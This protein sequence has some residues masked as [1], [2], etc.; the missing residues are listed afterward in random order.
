[1]LRLFLFL[2]MSQLCL[3][4]E[5]V[6]IVTGTGYPP[7][8]TS[9]LKGGGKA[10]KLIRD[11]FN[12]AGIN[13]E[14]TWMPWK[15]AMERSKDG[16]FHAIFP[17][18]KTEQRLKDF[19][20]ST[21][22][23]NIKLF[24]YVKVEDS[25]LSLNDFFSKNKRVCWPVGYNMQDMSK[26][27]KK[28]GLKL[29]RPADMKTCFLMLHKKRVDSVHSNNYL[30]TSLLQQLGLTKIRP[31]NDIISRRKLHILFPKKLKSSKELQLR[32]NKSL[33]KLTELGK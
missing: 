9:Q 31:I 5:T 18:T 1:M 29:I 19:H 27:Q 30:A 32:F 22:L 8:T 28:Y 10:V 21:P 17:Y 3:A 25:H 7:F 2:F 26:L 16:E 15:R 20:F 11:V 24:M 14:L 4:Q 12:S 23:Y 33:K 13:I 6:K